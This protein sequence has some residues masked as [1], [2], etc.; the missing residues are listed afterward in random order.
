MLLQMP[1]SHTASVR[2]FNLNHI[3]VLTWLHLLS[4][5]FFVCWIRFPLI[6]FLY[7][8]G[9]RQSFSVWGGFPGPE[10]EV[11]W[12]FIY[13]FILSLAKRFTKY[14][15]TTFQLQFILWVACKAIQ[16]LKEI[17]ALSN[18]VEI[19]FNRYLVYEGFLDIMWK[20]NQPV[21]SVLY[22]MWKSVF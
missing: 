17:S 15:Y 12:M 1:F 7:E 9:W 3:M 6:S 22:L 2:L 10:K 16:L 5:V 4:C 19:R 18:A 20:L 21:M 8:R 13:F 14:F 11:I